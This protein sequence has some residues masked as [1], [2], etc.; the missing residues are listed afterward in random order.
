[1][2]SK[3]DLDFILYDKLTDEKTDYWFEQFS[4]KSQHKF[5]IVTRYVNGK[6]AYCVVCTFKGDFKEK[7]PTQPLFLSSQINWFNSK[8]DAV[9]VC[10]VLNQ[11]M[12]RRN[13][14]NV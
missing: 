7:D 6:R 14:E 11:T 2:S 3:Y 9:M 10:F 13:K 8:R 5:I 12:D 4:E 1:M